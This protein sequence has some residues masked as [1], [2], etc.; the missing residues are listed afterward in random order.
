MKTT[1]ARI[2]D[3]GR[4]PQIEG[5]RLTVMDV[6]YYLHRGRDFDFIHRAMPSLTRDEFDAV[7]DYVNEHHDKLV[8]D[9]R[10]VEEWI[11]REIA[12]QEAKGLRPKI[13]KSVPREE[14]IARMKEKLRRRIKE[15]AEK[16]GGHAPD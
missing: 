13:D 6:F 10:L 5:H 15:Q 1:T 16:N 2:V 9:D 14:R 3:I 11:K 12:D 4:G 7:V 8:E